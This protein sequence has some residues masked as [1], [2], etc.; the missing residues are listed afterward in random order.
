MEYEELSRL[1]NIVES[2]LAQ[3]G[4]LRQEKEELEAELERKK[5]ELAELREAAAQLKEE[6]NVIHG[7]VNSLISSLEKWEKAQAGGPPPLESPQVAVQQDLLYAGPL[8][9]NGLAR[10]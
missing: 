8:E 9:P 10:G 2:L 1:E 6:K 3:F 5:L 4:S 7:R